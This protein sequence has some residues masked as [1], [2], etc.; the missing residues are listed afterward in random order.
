MGNGS[1]LLL[2][3]DCFYFYFIL[4]RLSRVPT[5]IIVYIELYISDTTTLL[6][7]FSELVTGRDLNLIYFMNL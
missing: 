3:K 5:H 6:N 4:S 7:S 2:F 1:V